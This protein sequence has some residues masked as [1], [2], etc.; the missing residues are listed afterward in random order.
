VTGDLRERLRDAAV[1]DEAGARERA[2]RVVDAAFAER[3][4]SPRPAPRRRPLAIAAGAVAAAVAVAVALTPPGEAVGEWV[5]NIVAPAP[6]PVRHVRPV[7]G[8]LPGHGRLL[9]TAPSGAW[10]LQADGTRRRLGAY[11]EATWSPRGLFVAVARGSMLAAVDPRGRLRWTLTRPRRVSHPTWSPDGFRVAYRSGREL[12]VVYGDGALDK[13][14]AVGSAP[15]T[16]AWWPGPAHRLAVV[17][18]D[19]RTV[20]VRDT[21]TG[22]V[23]WRARAA[24]RVLQLAW[25][26][27]GR[28]LLLVT[29]AAI[30][31]LAANGRAR[32]VVPAPAGERMRRAAWLPGGGLAV[33]RADAA[34]ATSD[35]VAVGA[36]TQR[37]LLSLPGRLTGLVA[38]PDGRWLLL[39]A[40]DA[41][42]WLLVRTSGPARLTALSRV[43]RQFDPGGRGPAALPRLDGWIR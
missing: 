24:G 41:G 17:A 13:R 33:L 4:R 11:D 39:A 18:R 19:R 7:L 16:P 21:D 9:V 40:P 15:V 43:G 6:S 29:P 36:R 22:R 32:R 34:E 35:V 30:R 26:P 20:V 25:S 10:I 8:P 12:R 37:P 31:V 1:P 42:Q 5:R 23:L 14:L 2:W 28:R 38:S 27:G 3:D